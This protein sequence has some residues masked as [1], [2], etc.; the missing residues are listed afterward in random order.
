MKGG[1]KNAHG[2][3][4]KNVT[5]RGSR[6]HATI[7]DMRNSAG[8]GTICHSLTVIET[9]KIALITQRSQVQILPPLLRKVQVR[10]LIADLGGRAFDHVS[11]EC[12]HALSQARHG[13]ST[14]DGQSR[15]GSASK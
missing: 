13:P 5:R 11:A 12:R 7:R 14:C 6:P 2:M 4:T 9:P 15:C 3:L 1:P 8:R 10:D